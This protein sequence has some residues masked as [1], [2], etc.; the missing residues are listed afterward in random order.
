MAFAMSCSGL[1]F[2]FFKGWYF[3]CFLMCYFP[4]MFLMSA[5]IQIAFSK[6]FSENMKAYGQ[7]ACYAEQAL[8]AIKVVFAFGQ[9]Q[10]EMINYEKY[11]AKAR[12]VGIKTHFMGGLAVGGFFL[13][14][15]G[16]YSYSFF[17]GSFMVTQE[18]KNDNS[19]K[20][21]SSGDIMACFLGLVYG[22]FSLGLA[23]PNFKALTEGRVAGKM[24]FDVIERKPK[25]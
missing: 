16:F 23:A 17:I 13:A 1:F 11:L 7:S 24:A 19:G 15:Y 8:N 9:E 14:L 3:S 22:V 2:A 5:S 4:F 10:I 25:I 18:I 6:G 20:I 21:Y 12:K